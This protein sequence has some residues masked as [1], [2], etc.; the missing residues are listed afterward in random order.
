MAQGGDMARPCVER[1]RKNEEAT[2]SSSENLPQQCAPGWKATLGY[3]KSFLTQ[4]ADLHCLAE[5]SPRHLDE[6]NREVQD[7]IPYFYS[8]TVTR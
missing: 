4:K 8:Q 2:R 1:E 3:R 7:S 5:R 6:K